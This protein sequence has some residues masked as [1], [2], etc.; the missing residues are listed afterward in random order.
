LFSPALVT[1]HKLLATILS[2]VKLFSVDGVLYYHVILS[3]KDE[4]NTGQKFTM[5]KG[6]AIAITL[7][8]FAHSCS[9]GLTGLDPILLGPTKSV[10][11]FYK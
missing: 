10:L 9:D 1:G 6:V 5:Q 3:H 7:P 8:L 11:D 4:L 2:Q